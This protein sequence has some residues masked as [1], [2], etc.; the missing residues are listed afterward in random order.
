MNNCYDNYEVRIAVDH[1]Q[2]I[3]PNE[4]GRASVEIESKKT[5]NDGGLFIL[6]IDRMPT[7]PGVRFAF[8][9]MGPNWPN[10]GEFD[11]LEGWAGRGADELTLHSGEGYDMSVVLNET[12]VLPVM[13]GVWKKYSNG[14]ASTNCS[15]SPINDAGC[16]VN[17]PNGTFGQEFNDVGGGLYIAEWD[18]ENYVRMWVIKRPDI[19]VDI[20]Q[21]F[22]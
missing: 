13:T 4:W 19:P 3:P 5:W 1:T 22:V 18:K 12:G 21:V 20:T 9:T 7:G 2:V 10:N 14:I 16:S 6:D 15:S 8:W 17:A 11:I